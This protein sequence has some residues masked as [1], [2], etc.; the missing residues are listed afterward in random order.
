MNQT[1][2]RAIAVV[3]VGAVLPDA[4]NAP[5][6]WKNI[7]TKRYSITDV[8]PERWS[9]ADYY[10]PDP[11]V[12]DK[13]YSKIGSWVRGFQFDWKQFR[14]PP[15]V[16]AAMDES[17][18]WAVT[19]AAEALADYGYPNRPLNTER[20]GV[21]LGTA[22]GGELHYVSSLRI[23][24]PE[25]AHVLENAA[26]FK[27]LP[28]DVRAALM[29]DVRSMV[30]ER[31]PNTTEDTMPGELANIVAGRIANV[32]NL[33]GPSF[34]TDA[35]CA[36]TFAAVEA[37]VEN[38]IN[39]RCDAVLTG[40]V[41]R[42]MGANSFVKFS[43]IGALSASG[44]RPFGDGADGFVM[45]EG[46]AAFLLKRLSDAERDGD[47]IYAVIRGVGGSSDGK[48]KGI[49]APNP[50][51]QRLAT[52]RAWENAGLDP[53][54]ATL[55][56]AHGTSTKVGDVVEVE[57]LATIFGNAPVGSIALGS[58]KSNI[59]HLKAGAGAAG[60]LKAVMAVN[61]K[62]LPPT[63]N[64]QKP[65][66]NLH[67]EAMPFFIN[68]DLQA[69]PQPA[70]SPRRAGVS[71]YGFGGTNFHVVVEEHVPGALGREVATYAGVNVPGSQAQPAASGSTELAEVAA[72]T[73]AP[74]AAAVTLH[75]PTKTPLRG[76][77]AVGAASPVELKDKLDALWRRVEDGWT[78][79]V[80][81]P[82]AEDLIAQERLVIDFGASDE[83]L[84]RLGKARKAAGF[85]NA[86]AWKALQGQGVFRGSGPK[87]GKVAFLFP[88][89][90]S[91]YANMGRELAAADPVVAEV[92]AEGDRVMTPILGK[93]LTSYI[94]VDSNDPQAMKRVE[95]DLMQTAITQP[96][97]LTIDTAIYKL[98]ATYG[99]YPDMVMGHSLGEYGALIAA[100]IMPFADALEA[101]AAR[102]SE[103]TKVSMGDNGWMAAV[104]APYSVIE[105]TLPKIKGYIVAANINSYSQSV[106]GG[107]SK[108]VEEA[109][110]VFNGMGYQAVRLPV[111]H[112]FHTRIVAPASKPLRQVLNRLRIS[113]PHLPLVGNV[114]G[115]FYPNDV[116]GIKDLLELQI[117]SPV[118]WIKGLET[119][120]AAGARTF[121][122]VGAKKALKGLVDDVLGSKPDVVSLFTNHPKTGELQSFNQALCGLYA[123]G[124]GLTANQP[125]WELKDQK[126][127]AAVV[128]PMPASA[129]PVSA[130]AAP[131]APAAA[132]MP[133]EQ[134]F[135]MP[136]LPSLPPAQAFQMMGQMF[137][138]MMQTMA[139]PAPKTFDR[140]DVPQGSIVISGTGLGLP[141]VNKSVMDPD[142]ALRILRGEQFVDLI[143][144]RY[145]RV[146]AEKH[147][148]R[149][150]KAADGS[151]SFE[152]ITDSGDVIKLAGRAGSFDLSEEYG[153]PDKLVEA[154]DITTQLA[155]AAGLDALREA[156]IPLVQTWK[157]TSTGRYLPDR[158]MLPESLRDETGIIFASAFP[159]GDR[160]ADEMRR[161]YIWQ[162]RLHHLE[163]L[164]ELRG[165]VGENQALLEVDRRINAVR[166]EL[167]REPYIFDRRFIFRIL[168]MGHSQFAEYIGARGPNTQ[169]NAACASTAQGVAIAEDWIRSGRCRRVIVVGADDVTSDNLMEWVG[170]GFLATGAA[171][172]DDKVEEAAL[173]F[174]RRR[175]GTLLGMGAC[176][177]VVESEDAVRERGMRGI[178]ELLSSETNNSAFH[179]TRLDVD[180]IAMVMNNLVTAAERRFGV[181]R[182]T[183]APQLVFMS[184]E[185]FTP[186]RGGSASAEVVALR[187]T[188][189][190]VTSQIIMA[191]T[192]GFTGHP[193][194]VGVEDVI[195]VKILEYGIVPPV[196]NFKEVDPDLGVLNLSRG[197]RYPV[198]YA[199]HLAA[200]FGSQIAMTLTRHIP[201]ALDRTDN[202]PLY[203]RWLE[204]VSGYDRAETEVVKRVLRVRSDAAPTRQPAPNTWR[205]GTGPVVRTLAAGDGAGVTHPM[206][207]PMV[208]APPAP[209]APPASP[210]IAAPPPAP[211]A[212][213]PTPSEP[214]PSA[215]AAQPIAPAPAAQ[216]IAPAPVAQPIAPTPVAQPIAPAP[217]IV[218]APA[219]PAKDTV[220]ERVLA[221]VAEK[222]GYPSDMLDLEL[223]LE[224]DLG[225]DTV[226]QAETFAAV[227]D[228]FDIPRRDD[229]KL[230]D[231]PTLKRVV[232]FVHESRPDLA[233]APVAAPA[234]L[235][236][237]PPAETQEAVTPPPT[238]AASPV[239]DR[240]L[241]IVAEKTGYPQD[242]LDL[243]LDLEADLGIDTVKQAE[244]F[245]A[246]RE[247]FDIPRRDDVKL[248]DYPTLKRV[249]DFVRESRPDLA[250]EQTAPAAT[251]T[252]APVAQME[253]KPASQAPVT[254]PSAPAAPASV[255]TPASAGLRTQ[256]AEKVLAVVAEK[257]GYPQDMLDL[258]LD[259]EADLGIDTV[260]QAETF[261]AIRQAFDIP[262]RD[263]IKLRDYPTL[264]SVIQ[265]VLSNRPELAGGERT[266][267][268]DRVTEQ[269]AT[270][271]ATT[272][273]APGP[274]SAPSDLRSAVTDKVLTVVAEKTGY[275]QDMLDLE[276]DMEADLGI[277]TV[278][279]A[280]TFS[281]IRQAFDIPRRDDIKLRD[282]PT[283]A[284]VIQFVLSNR[285][286][287][288][289]GERTETRDQASGQGVAAAPAAAPA[290][291][292]ADLRS[293]VTD[294]VLTVV[295][296]K[297]GYPQDMLD[298]ELDMEADLGIDTVKQAETFSAIRQAFDIPR[299]DD[300]KLR[301]YPTL[302]SVIQFVQSNRP[303]LAGEQRPETGD[304]VMGQGAAAPSPISDARPPVSAPPPP[305]PKAIVKTFGTLE[306][307][308]K[309]PRRVVVPSVRPALEFCK[310]TGVAL[311]ASS[312]VVVM[313]DKGGVGKALVS[314]LQKRGVTVLVL[315]D[316]P[317]MDALVGQ[318]QDWLAAGPIQG[319]YWLPALDAEPGLE[320][321]DL[322]AWRE[323]NRVRVKNLYATM[324][325]LFQA[326]SGPA[327]F[328]VAGVR[329][330][331]L[332]G[333]GPEGAL[334]PLGGGVVGFSK[335]F[336]REREQALV[337]AVD[338]DASRKTAEPAEA[339]IAETLL[340][341]GVIEVGYRDGVRYS[342][343]LQ[344]LPARD[345][346]VGLTLGKDTVFVV[347]GAAGG[348]TSA[349]TTDLAVASEGIFYL[350]DVVPPPQR[351][352][353]DIR[354]F[355]SDKEALKKALIERA[356][357][358]GKKPTP[359]EIDKQIITIERNE[360]AL[361]AIETVE[362]AGGTAHYHS[363]NLLDGESVAAVVSDI[364]QRYGRIDV[365]LHAGGL[366][367]DKP[368]PDKE[369]NQFAL[370]FDVKAD[371]FFNLL[372]AAAGL[373]IGAT[374]VFSSVAGRF[375]NAAQSDYSAANDLLCKI[376]SSMKAWRPQTRGI[377]LDWTAWGSI[378][379]ATRGSVPKVMEML[380]I[381]MLPPEVGVP[382]IRRELTYSAF[383]GEIVVGQRLGA[384]MSEQDATGGLDL[385]KVQAM[386]A[387]RQ[388][389]LPMIGAVKAARLYGGLE[390]ETT[391]D[392]KA[393]PFLFDHQIDGVPVLPGVMGTESFAELATLLFPGYRVA[394]IENEQF[395]APFKFFRHQPRTLYLEA[396]ARAGA[397]GEIVAHTTLTGITPAPKPELPPQ[398]KVHFTAD[399]RLTAADPESPTVASLSTPIGKTVAAADIYKIYFHGPAYQVLDEVGMADGVVV[400]R[401]THLLPPNTAPDTAET[402][403]APRLIEFCFQ[404]AGIWEMATTGVMAL[405]MAIGRV[406][407][408]RQPEQ[409]NGQRL[410]ARVTPVDGGKSFDAIVADESGNVYVEMR[411]Y[412]TVRMPGSVS[413]DLLAPLQAILA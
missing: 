64:A 387:K 329:L 136:T 4:P 397:N 197:G 41:D 139:Q 157:R 194:G 274:I 175:H 297:T 253:P 235:E 56:E 149:V 373:P 337:K 382:T 125:A 187:S 405:P 348:I 374:V 196:P 377:A 359:V 17:Q 238:A 101:A 270:A 231:Y 207:A 68:H 294:K 404:T 201:G 140:N 156:G 2:D 244:T 212:P 66:P 283:L 217:V 262:R 290:P 227:R 36:S 193:M 351:D 42:N 58:A 303:D 226:K 393:Q 355:R 273:A 75:A 22:M 378:G 59:G 372:K 342:P 85:D 339:L 204:D 89:Q 142:N 137:A 319:V 380:G 307:S 7:R 30:Q 169:V 214:L 178:V 266:E 115:D 324:R 318:L 99:Q 1:A 396:T 248:R 55:V 38:L 233:A 267:T 343:T 412:Q 285:P 341:P 282:Y 358:A 32:F 400:G 21:I 388:R 70:H 69:W 120:Y 6:F 263:D 171:A 12:P 275:P 78:P 287:L 112:A 13:T 181:D 145:R 228:A 252:V 144:E 103:M 208:I 39:F 257:T 265:F 406:T 26:A 107:E 159:G 18:Q 261:A 288:A 121:V 82:A 317:A 15:K 97:M 192:K 94:F 298:L 76:I 45:G 408:H 199:L 308:E 20:T 177:L 291:V 152:T 130:A 14:I 116:E 189:G 215:P 11:S 203:Q 163:M 47:K 102:G 211:V 243:E 401:M 410:Y 29:A 209:V 306:E 286:E 219:A 375:G 52:Q 345:G 134:D 258:E 205:V 81:P 35:A 50:I 16:A 49:T 268:R 141:G 240:V 88:G 229:V 74:A 91:Q 53:A 279:Q 51:G 260:K 312:R 399:V 234:A 353:E 398:V 186:A 188:F 328:L 364:R 96:A 300:I 98:L 73:A 143:P 325:A 413:A 113:S 127:A 60:L 332:H 296:E 356:R 111:S 77:L 46:A 79:A 322:A 172:T 33:R 269:G 151:G 183:M 5:A 390:V 71:A 87:P 153:V 385:D 54:T 131:A 309:A 129:S 246:V 315:E 245:A 281:A 395:M 138:Q 354:L 271:A 109:I 237:T 305:K 57:S 63:L 84:D 369:P 402:V 220:V 293:V 346:S 316:A 146:M 110:G 310:P 295:A 221:L 403:M 392:P 158:W 162:E 301:D 311:D 90:G 334:A 164:Q 83:L 299:R 368:L 386:L 230:R 123:A 218:E 352:D 223:D 206:P 165:Y 330:G 176:A 182:R 411:G 167:A 86:A 93:P 23:F 314:R 292:S 95:R 170:A 242:M 118:Q 347:T 128:A 25:Y 34:I 108:A 280:E 114:Y 132:T 105:E 27:Q 362:A 224:A 155:M 254:T 361:R 409:A 379:M 80:A 371:G 147:V 100:G 185:T 10:D 135:A 383:K 272:A 249:V 335:A 250:V 43:K 150:V 200:G 184:H 389:P 117:A 104:M 122:E 376:S 338:F 174:D 277:D 304:R 384:L 65:N 210:A 148:T 24:F 394:A 302:A 284:S 31:F 276:L 333:Y 327:N 179:G 357:A 407:T 232:D 289:G 8:P 195:A 180:H 350:L 363:I 255:P 336:K 278:K 321:M 247:A 331:G 40:G 391:L 161:Y 37:A 19:I 340:D 349:I 222:T 326:I 119:L 320:E 191:N 126:P 190:D 365:L 381:D 236:K 3:G 256:V 61:D 166:D 313:M 264:G 67:F 216:P 323:A 367:I 124:Y 44:S 198:Q 48:G 154:L 202:K 62:V 370:V 241:A 9:V 344:V 239:I 259:M 106:I 72:A 92:F 173:P 160:F 213:K 251:P 225:I 366:L 360:A 168:A 28:A 133:T